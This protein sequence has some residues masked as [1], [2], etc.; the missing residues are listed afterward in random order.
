MFDTIRRPVVALVAVLALLAGAAVALANPAAAATKTKTCVAGDTGYRMTVTVEYDKAN[1]LVDVHAITEKFE[2]R[3]A[4][5]WRTEDWA[6]SSQDW[7]LVNGG[8]V[9]TGSRNPGATYRW[10]PGAAA[11]VYDAP[12]YTR[13]QATGSGTSI[14]NCRIDL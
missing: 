5:L 10:V 8:T 1:G 13:T 14:T 12:V 9:K 6:S 7:Y 2:H 3:I 11:Q 4:G